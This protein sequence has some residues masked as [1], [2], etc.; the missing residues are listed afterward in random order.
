MRKST[1]VIISLCLYWAASAQIEDSIKLSNAVLYYSVEGSGQPVLLLSGGPGTSANILDQ[2]FHTLS[3]N[4]R[5]ILLEQR[6]TGKSKTYPMDSSTINLKNAVE[7]IIALLNK[8]RLKKISIVGHSYGAM[9]AM[10]FASTYPGTLD[11]LVLVG[12]GVL[13]QDQDFAADNR[14]SKLSVE[15]ILFSR[16]VQDSIANN[17]ASDASQKKMD[18]MSMRLNLYDAF[19]ADSILQVISNRQRNPV[20]ERLML[21]DMKKHYNVRGAV[22]K[23]TFPFMVISGRQDPVA[24]FPTMDIM[25]LNRSAKVVW[26]NRSGHIPWLEQ[27]KSF[28]ETIIPFLNQ[29]VS[30]RAR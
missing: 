27:P 11:K 13:S 3:K 10:Q 26:I 6:G 22:A 5:C 29:D 8:L 23:F 24:V 2:L 20:M 12:P 25:Q 14:R 4:Y 19:K 15:E 28:Y 9:L 21:M 30:S 17:T 18:A 16:K 1:L 7:D